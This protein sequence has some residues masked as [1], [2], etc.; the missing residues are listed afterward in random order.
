[1]RLAERLLPWA[2]FMVAML[3]VWR[4][5]D[6]FHS[7]PLY[8]DGME[9]VV[10]VTWF[11]DAIRHGRSLLIYP[12]NYFPEGWRVATHSA[13]MIIYVLLWPLYRLGGAAF[14]FN[15]AIVFSSL[16]AFAGAYL[17]ARNYLNRVI[18]IL[19]ALMFTFGSLRWYQA[20]NGRMQILIGSVCLPWMLWCLERAFLAER[21]RKA[22]LALAGVLWALAF[23]IGQYFVFLGGISLAVWILFSPAGR[24]RSW[25]KKLV[26]L[27]FTCAVF[28]VV[29]APWLLLTLRES[30]IADPPFY[31]IGEV[32]FSGAS[33][34]SLPIPS[35]F[36]PVLGPLM[37]KL[38]A[39]EPWEQGAANLGL[40]MA[41]TA[42]AGAI[43]VRKDRTWR[44]VLLMTSIFLVLAL[45][46]TL[47]WNGQPVQWSVFR[48]LNETLWRLGHV[49]KPGFFAGLQPHAEFVNAVPLPGML[50][51]I[52]VPFLER[53][54]M[55]ARYV[56]PASL[57]IYL[58]AGLVLTRIRWR[59]LQVM[60]AA[61]LIFEFLPPPLENLPYP[62]ATHP[63]FEWLKQQ[64]LGDQGILDTYAG[65]PSTLV[66]SINGETL[67]ATLYH[68]QPTAGGSAGVVPRHAVFLA[69]WLA[70]HP[71]TFW[72]PDFAQIMR[73]YRIGMWSCRCVASM[74][75]S[76]GMRPKCL[77]TFDLST[78]LIPRTVRMPGHGRFASL[79]Y[80][81]PPRRTS[82]CYGEMAGR[83]W[84]T[85]AYG[86]KA[87][88]RCPVDCHSPS[89]AT[90]VGCSVSTMLA[91][92]S[93]ADRT[94]GERECCGNS[95]VAGLR[96][97]ERNRRHSRRADAHRRQ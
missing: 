25:T 88:S 71:H 29:S 3:W 43:I 4:T 80:R 73:S 40:V 14:A 5:R 15:M 39:G 84:K 37:R 36:H 18:A 44:P 12:L 86:L 79:R 54:R 75:R 60:L 82:T 61:V 94:G 66:L 13:G 24:P 35:L 72:Q 8:G 28:A 52:L 6:P 74:N 11:D 48:P 77:T 95:P 93:T 20:W 89:P 32:N 2:A 78:A 62:P 90:P 9:T 26:D 65:N 87:R 23:M 50:L 16:L 46:L 59:W 83:A 85:G 53:G 56:L 55:F 67:L 19:P 31:A 17:L 34:N 91:R 51:T 27:V 57:G 92:P 64:S 97:V 10:G 76:F 30:A 70:S 58:L 21:R 22:W 45:G 1:M 7:L 47:H 68:N 42:V 81:R 69:D 38:Y 33:L 41:I 63:A 49:L 96:A